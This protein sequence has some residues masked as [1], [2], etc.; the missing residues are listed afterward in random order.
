M[1]RSDLDRDTAA[2]A[3]L[4]AYLEPVVEDASP[5]L[6]ETIAAFADDLSTR[7]GLDRL[8]SVPP[9]T[10]SDARTELLARLDEAGL[11]PFEDVNSHWETV[12]AGLPFGYNELVEDSAATAAHWIPLDDQRP[13][14]A[15]A[16]AM[17][18][19]GAIKGALLAQWRRA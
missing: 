5:V 8:G 4:L 15:I 6:R 13:R 16:S 7:F 19:C 14:R 10:F 11:K 3:R 9:A 17:N 2:V 12:G 18:G 1:Y